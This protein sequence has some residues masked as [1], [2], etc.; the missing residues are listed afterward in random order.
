VTRRA[1]AEEALRCEDE[2]QY[3]AALE[4]TIEELMR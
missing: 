4:S 1:I 2:S 3:R